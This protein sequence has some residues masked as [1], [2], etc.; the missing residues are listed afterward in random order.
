MCLCTVL[1]E[2]DLSFC[3]GGVWCVQDCQ[4]YIIAFVFCTVHEQSCTGFPRV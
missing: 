1:L 4:Y 2:F 3:R